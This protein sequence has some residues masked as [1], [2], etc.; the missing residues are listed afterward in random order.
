M[1]APKGPL[2]GLEIDHIGIA[3]PSLAQGKLFYEALGFKQMST[4][5]VPSE[6]VKVGFLQLDNQAAIE[7]LEP[8]S[9]ESPVAKFIDKR[10]PGIHHICLRVKDIKA[11][12]D[13]LKAKGMQLINSEPKKGAHNCWVAF[14]HPK[15]TGGV[16]IELSQPAQGEGHE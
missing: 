1:K 2:S 4:E 14:V 3:V 7:L 13:Q 8:T 11:T 15:S 16:L 5:E 9:P 6:M 10:G 12:M